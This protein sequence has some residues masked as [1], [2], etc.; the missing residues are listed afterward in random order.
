M[1]YEDSLDAAADQAF[2]LRDDMIAERLIP[3]RRCETED[4]EVPAMA[5]GRDELCD[6]HREEVSGMRR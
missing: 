1:S 4:T 6:R 5:T 3:C 2:D